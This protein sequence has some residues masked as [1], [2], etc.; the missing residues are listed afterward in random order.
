MSTGENRCL[1]FHSVSITVATNSFH[2]RAGTVRPKFKY[3][4]AELEKVNQSY[5]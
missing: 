1:V 5:L 4:E 2:V 3:I